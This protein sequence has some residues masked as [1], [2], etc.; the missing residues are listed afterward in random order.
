[1]KYDFVIF[2]TET[3]QNR[4]INDQNPDLVI[5]IF[6][7]ETNPFAG[8]DLTGHSVAL[9]M[10]KLKASTAKISDVAFTDTTIASGIFTFEFLTTHVDDAGTY[11]CQIKITD[12]GGKVQ[13]VEKTFQ[14][15]ISER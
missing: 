5:Q 1:M 3:T 10:K 8:L 12:T 11:N 6:D 14:I 9:N 15:V 13:T 7:N 2:N 4:Y